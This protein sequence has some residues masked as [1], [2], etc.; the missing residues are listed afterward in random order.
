MEVY[1]VDVAKLRHEEQLLE[2]D[3]SKVEGQAKM[4]PL[5]DH[6]E[7]VA[8]IGELVHR[9]EEVRGTDEGLELH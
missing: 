2:D 5:A 4:A 3:T 8:S 9:A 7:K 6:A 1:A